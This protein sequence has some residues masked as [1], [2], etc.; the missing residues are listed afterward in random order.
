MYRR[1]TQYFCNDWNLIDDWLYSCR[2]SCF[3]DNLSISWPGV[4][5]R[6]NRSRMMLFGV[7]LGFHIT[8]DCCFPRLPIGY[9]LRRPKCNIGCDAQIPRHPLPTEHIIR[10]IHPRPPFLLRHRPHPL[11]HMLPLTKR[12]PRE[13]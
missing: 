13:M 10:P 8:L 7:F 2:C 5:S 4:L 6:G 11:P 9:A 3:F 1:L 12:H